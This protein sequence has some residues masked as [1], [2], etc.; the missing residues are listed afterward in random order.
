M[1][2]VK[3]IFILLYWLCLL[4]NPYSINIYELCPIPAQW[5]FI[6]LSAAGL[7]TVHR[8]RNSGFSE[9]SL[10]QKQMFMSGRQ[11]NLN[12]VYASIDQSPT[13]KKKRQRRK[14]LMIKVSF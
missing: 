7:L 13:K 12:N 14:K 2:I 6:C 10:W 3:I 5:K 9:V 11:Y 4:L 8:E 1:V